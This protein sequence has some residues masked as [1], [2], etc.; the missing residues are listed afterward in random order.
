VRNSGVTGVVERVGD[1]GCEYMTGGAI[2]VLGETGKNF[3]AGMSGGVAYV[4]DPDGTFAERANTGMVSLSEDL[5]PDDEA[6]LTRLV[7]NHAA[8]T[9]SKRAERLLANWEGEIEQFTRVMPDA[10]AEVIEQRE[11]DDVRLELPPAAANEAD[12]SGTVAQSGAD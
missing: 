10:Y 5:E 9:D 6:L 1:H 4:Y 8:Y 3:A 2:V 7:E 12:A 11:R